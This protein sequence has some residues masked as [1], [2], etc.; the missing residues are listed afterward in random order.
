MNL[1]QIRAHSGKLF[2]RIEDSRRRQ[3]LAAN[4]IG[5]A[6]SPDERFRLAVA[7][8]LHW[9]GVVLC[10]T[11]VKARGHRRVN[12]VLPELRSSALFAGIDSALRAAGIIAE[13]R[14]LPL[15]VLSLGNELDMRSRLM[16]EKE[17]RRRSRMDDGT[18][19]ELVGR[20][21]LVGLETTTED[22]WIPTH[23]TTAHAVSSAATLT[24][25]INVR[26]VLYLIQD[27]EPGFTP[28]STDFAL[29]RATYHAGFH[30]VVNSMPLAKYLESVEQLEVPEDRV[31]RPE[32]DLPALGQ[33][34]QN[35]RKR[36][37]VLFYGRPSKPRNLFNLGVAVLQK[38]AQEVDG[39]DVDVEFVSAGEA[40]A[41]VDL[42]GTK[43]LRVA[44]RLSWDSY[45]DLIV[46]SDV[47]LSLQHSPHPSHPPLD[48]VVRGCYAV[49]N[50]FGGIRNALSPLI[51]AR[52]PR[53]EELAD[54]VLEALCA[55]RMHGRP[56]PDLDIVAKLGGRLE[57][58]MQRAAKR[59]G[60]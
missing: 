52:E 40:H 60:K 34:P 11:N 51:S 15:R 2:A 55:V 50:E 49:T 39:W 28:W 7:A 22:I 46:D 4:V 27:Y 8:Q 38:V 18:P 12:L 58:V 43:S 54:A 13:D 44:G 29:A 1:R 5:R 3:K 56:R 30:Y 16:L 24:G 37:R 25:D 20:D 45:F 57:D 17:I 33:A 53:I 42:T 19:I 14:G 59:V 41:A 36:M 23:W 6:G 47:L 32:V 9:A 35:D 48:A 10:A 31:F 26:N 21:R